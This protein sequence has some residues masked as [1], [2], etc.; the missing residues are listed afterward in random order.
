VFAA[1]VVLALIG[2]ILFGLTALAQR[3][4]VTWR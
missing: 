2:V 3:L 4:V 1:V